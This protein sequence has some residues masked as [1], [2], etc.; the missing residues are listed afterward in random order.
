MPRMNRGHPVMRAPNLV[1]RFFSATL[2]AIGIYSLISVQF[3]AFWAPLVPVPSQLKWISGAAS[4]LGGLG[5]QQRKTAHIAASIL[6]A[7][8][9]IWLALFKAPAIFA[10]PL[11]AASWESMAET[12]VITAAVLCLFNVSTSDHVARLL[13]GSA[14]C[15]F[16]IAHFAYIAQTAALVPKWLPAHVV[17]VYFT[18][19]VFVISGAALILG[20][21]ARK[22]TILVVIQMGLFTILV[23]LP[24][25]FAEIHDVQAVS[26][27]L[28]S[29]SLTAAAAIIAQSIQDSRRLRLES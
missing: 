28:D 6:L 8:L 16:G 20:I 17:L 27:F 2:I 25:V 11:I 12:L 7:T 15:L 10:A 9:V 26:E 3:V 19:A 18:G 5:L 29:A 24:K 1:S 21:A 22:F 14:M 23:W 13:A 4:L